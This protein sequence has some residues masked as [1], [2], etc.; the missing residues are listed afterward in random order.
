MA[1]PPSPSAQA[2]VSPA[3]QAQCFF[4]A[5]SVYV[6]LQQ[7]CPSRS[8]PVPTPAWQQLL[9]PLGQPQ[10]VAVLH[11]HSPLTQSG[12]IGS[13]HALP[14]PPQFFASVLVSTHAP[15]QH[16]WP[17]A[18]F[19][20]QFLLASS[21]FWHLPAIALGD[22]LSAAAL[23]ARLARREADELAAVWVARQARWQLAARRLRLR[24]APEVG[25]LAV[26]ASRAAH[27]SSSP[28]APGPFGQFGRRSGRHG[29]R[30]APHW[31]SRERRSP[32]PKLRQAAAAFV[33]EESE[34]SARRARG[35]QPQGGAPG[36]VA[37]NERVQVSKRLGSI[38]HSPLLS[39]AQ[40]AESLT[41][42]I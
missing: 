26:V 9:E 42:R 35:Q 11:W 8:T 27:D 23:L 32:L 34:Q 19:D 10:V 38:T 16:V 37:N 1:K 40:L 13:V 15:P 21:H 6:P 24:R 25:R 28:A 18:H 3:M 2:Q 17:L 31:R 33:A 29:S 30:A 36:A 12:A 5:G 39:P 7:H 14:H 22:A 4:P 41:K 20:L